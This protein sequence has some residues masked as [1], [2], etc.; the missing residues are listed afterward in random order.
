MRDRL[1]RFPVAAI[2]ALNEGLQAKRDEI[3]A[4]HGQEVFDD[5]V[6]GKFKPIKLE[7]LVK[8]GVLLQKIEGPRL[9]DMTK[10][11]RKV[12]RKQRQE[13]RRA[14]RLAKDTKV[15]ESPT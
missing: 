4:K 1:P 6:A 13:Q 8:H 5:A 14:V 15:E 7:F 11:E 12:A 3:V 9:K 2:A 10:E